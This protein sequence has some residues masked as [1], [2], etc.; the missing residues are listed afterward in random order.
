[1]APRQGSTSGY[2]TRILVNV[3]S[4]D[5]SLCMTYTGHMIAAILTLGSL[6]PIV[7]GLAGALNIDY[8]K[9]GGL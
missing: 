6:V 1:M 4:V 5:M 7:F 2:Q 8:G 9:R 3:I